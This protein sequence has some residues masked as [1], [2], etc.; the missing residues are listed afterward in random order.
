MLFIKPRKPT[1]SFHL[2]IVCRAD[3]KVIGEIWVY[4][5]ENDRMAKVAIR[6]SEQYQGRGYAAE[7]LREIVRQGG[8][9][10]L[11]THRGP[12]ALRCLKDDGLA[13]CFTDHVI[14]PDGFPAKPAPDALMYLMEKH[15]VNQQSA[16]MVGDRQLDLDAGKNAGIETVLFDPDGYYKDATPDVRIAKL[17]DL[18]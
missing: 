2:G 6:L 7:A 1:K 3:G 12:S 10:Y 16:V 18:L 9:N 11:F 8:R 14:R 15:G 17:T 13:D 5:I 4:L